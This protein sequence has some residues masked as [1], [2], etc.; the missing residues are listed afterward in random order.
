M[1]APRGLAYYL[2]P[3]VDGAEPTLN[4][5]KVFRAFERKCV[6][7]I[8]AFMHLFARQ[9]STARLNG[10]GVPRGEWYSHHPVTVLMS[11]LSAVNSLNQREAYK[12]IE[13][14]LDIAPG[15]MNI[16]H[17][18]YGAPLIRSMATESAP[19]YF[20][21]SIFLLMMEKKA[22]PNV[23]ETLRE[24]HIGVD[25]VSYPLAFA[26]SCGM[27]DNAKLLLSAKADPNALW[28]VLK[29]RDIINYYSPLGKA[30]EDSSF[31]SDFVLT[32]LSAG[33]DPDFHYRRLFI[34]PAVTETF[35]SI[36]FSF[37]NS[38]LYSVEAGDRETKLIYLV[39]FGA[40]LDCRKVERVDFDTVR[41]T[42]RGELNY[43]FFRRLGYI[44]NIALYI[45]RWELPGYVIRK[46]YKFDGKS[47]W[48]PLNHNPMLPELNRMMLLPDSKLQQVKRLSPPGS[49]G[50]PS[51]QSIILKMLIQ[52]AIK[53]F[54]RGWG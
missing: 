24:S 27:V 40:N 9:L 1:D 6:Q 30:V 42:D 35:G 25:L 29:G 51:L 5:E 26:M 52:E 41:F 18:F 17:P 48:N 4:L 2:D 44:Y 37:M 28:P 54:T 39:C 43:R 34:K 22:D 45:D 16:D 3:A 7:D 11:A 23:P 38:S 46:W 31:D 49:C 33:A 36:L 21:K 50:A 8:E 32:L 14:I 13:I 47:W 53:D 15:L 19:I 10:F 12:C 20:E